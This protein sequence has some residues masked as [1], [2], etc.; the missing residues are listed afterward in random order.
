MSL[1]DAQDVFASVN[2]AALNDFLTREP[3]RVGLD[4]AA[5]RGVIIAVAVVI[6]VAERLVC[7]GNPAIV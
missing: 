3:D 2:E 6:D 4:V 1:T 5:E 7:P